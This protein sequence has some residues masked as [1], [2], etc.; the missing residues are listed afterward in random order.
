MRDGRRRRR[1]DLVPVPE[2]TDRH[3][4]RSNDNVA[5]RTETRADLGR[6]MENLS[7]REQALLWLAYAQGASHDEIAESLGLKTSSIKQLLFRAR[8]RLAQL[9]R[10]D[11]RAPAGEGIRR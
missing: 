6:A 9:L 11:Q 3:A 5:G 1:L 7:S 4:L 8:R 2:E 10:G